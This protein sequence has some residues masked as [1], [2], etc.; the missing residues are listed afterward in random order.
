[1]A[2]NR[3]CSIPDCGKRH[4][5]RG[6][7]TLHY[8]RWK[9]YG[10]PNF[11]KL[12]MAPRGEP[13]EFLEAVVFRYEGDE[14]IVW[15]YCCFPSGYGQI[16]VDGKSQTVSRLVC[17]RRHGPPP[18]AGYDAAHSC[19]K[20]HLGCITPAHLAWKTRAGNIEDMIDHGTARR[21]ER[22]VNSK[23]TAGE[24]REIR[25]LKGSATQ[26]QL[27]ERFGVRPQAISRIHQ[28]ARWGW[29]E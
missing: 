10:D 26:R 29:L 25:A 13:R 21:G 28:N 6:W 23:L 18:G 12:E 9:R 22:A 8:Q 19:G 17:E 24:V 7:C 15:P 16:R 2:K 5:V 4:S 3:L 20:G 14:C 11:V 1:M 27:A